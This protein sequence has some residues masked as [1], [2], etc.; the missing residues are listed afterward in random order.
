MTEHISLGEIVAYAKAD[1]LPDRVIHIAALERLDRIAVAME[2]SAD[3][4]ERQAMSA[5]CL[6]TLGEN[7]AEIY[8][9]MRNALNEIR[10]TLG[11]FIVAIKSLKKE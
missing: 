2:R 10:G 5:S 4:A 9:R 6:V 1:S 7:T 8:D 3:A 11:T